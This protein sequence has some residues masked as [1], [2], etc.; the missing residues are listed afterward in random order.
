LHDTVGS[1]AHGR[2]DRVAD[3]GVRQIQLQLVNSVGICG[4]TC[5]M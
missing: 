1:T 3:R 4:S 2:G 5:G